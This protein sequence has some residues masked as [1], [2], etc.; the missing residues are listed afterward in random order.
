MKLA[1]ILS[2]LMPLVLGQDVSKVVNQLPII[3]NGEGQFSSQIQTNGIPFL[4]Q[5]QQ[6]IQ[7][8]LPS[9]QQFPISL[10]SLQSQ[11][12]SLGNEWTKQFPFLSQIQQQF[13]QQGVDLKNLS[14]TDW[15]FSQNIKLP[16]SFNKLFQGFGGSTGQYFPIS[17]SFSSLLSYLNKFGI[18]IDDKNVIAIMD[19]VMAVP[20]QAFINLG[21]CR[22][23]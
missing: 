2:L 7:D 11:F 10:Q 3:G 21:I 4:S 15:K 12:S 8:Q 18:T 9:S 20:T 16:E 5:F 22:K 23:N 13:Q 17:C 14:P 6:Q 19:Q 1:L